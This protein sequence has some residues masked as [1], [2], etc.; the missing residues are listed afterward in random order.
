MGFNQRERRYFDELNVF[1]L[2]HP[3][4]ITMLSNILGE[5][6]TLKNPQEGITYIE[7]EG[8]E[9]ERRRLANCLRSPSGVPAGPRSG[10]RAPNVLTYH[11]MGVLGAVVLITL[12]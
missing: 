8:E 5:A 3:D 6:H 7:E 2:Y 11:G 1:I 9:E 10:E 12:G 4:D